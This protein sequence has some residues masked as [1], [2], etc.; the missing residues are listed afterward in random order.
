VYCVLKYSDFSTIKKCFRITEEQITV[1]T[2]TQGPMPENKLQGSNE[3][4]PKFD[5]D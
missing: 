2:L 4:P 5:Y 3:S 1:V